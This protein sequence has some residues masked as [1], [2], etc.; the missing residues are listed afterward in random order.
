MR[1]AARDEMENSME[2]EIYSWIKNIVIYLII[3][4]VI[5]NFL[6]NKSYKKYV[7]IVSGMIL[8]LIVVSPLI[9]FMKL[10]ENLDYFL[11]SN[12]F[13]IESS[14]FKHNL[15]QMEEKQSNA[16]FAEY[17]EKIKKQ[18]EA[19]L[20]KE[21]VVLK[22]F[23]VVIDTKP[24]SSTYGEIQSMK[25]TAALKEEDEK[26][27]RLN[28]EQIEIPRINIRPEEADTADNVPS[29]LEINIKNNLSDFYNIEPGN[30]NISVQGG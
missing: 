6:G 28:I 8:V 16:I 22:S 26:E 15:S 1:R 11:Q 9:K 30:I 21:H 17:K 3:N 7:G 10:E 27:N 5:M 13:S 23:Q 24:D 20:L 29:P 14:D 2:E 25:I 18:V 12:D 4:T 19:L